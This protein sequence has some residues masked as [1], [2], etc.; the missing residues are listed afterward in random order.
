MLGVVEKK[1]FSLKAKQKEK[2][3]NILDEIFSSHY[4]TLSQSISPMN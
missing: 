3:K 4:A 2:Y 1:I